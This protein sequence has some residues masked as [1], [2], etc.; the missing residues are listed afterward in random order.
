MKEPSIIRG[1]FPNF[2]IFLRCKLSIFTIIISSI[3][4]ITFLPS[5]GLFDI[6]LGLYSRFE[7]RVPL[8]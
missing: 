4:E 7:A 8:I 6:K 2:K 3:E 1:L 5:S